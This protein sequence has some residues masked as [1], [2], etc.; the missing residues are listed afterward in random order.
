MWKTMVAHLEELREGSSDR[1]ILHEGIRGRRSNIRVED[2]RSNISFN[3]LLHIKSTSQNRVDVFKKEN[4][5]HAY[6]FFI[7]LE[8]VLLK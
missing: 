2:R 6:H 3:I 1:R 8:Y 5:Q 4:I 7:G